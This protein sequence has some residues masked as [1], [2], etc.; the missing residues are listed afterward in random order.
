VD[1]V[2]D[3]SYEQSGGYW[4][5][6]LGWLFSNLIWILSDPRSAIIW[7]KKSD[8]I[9]KSEKIWSAIWSGLALKKSDLNLIWSKILN[10]IFIRGHFWHFVNK[11]MFFYKISWIC[12]TF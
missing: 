6:F 8:L 10:K 2:C 12:I 4:S 11:L 5:V 1:N 9:W 3:C 7:S